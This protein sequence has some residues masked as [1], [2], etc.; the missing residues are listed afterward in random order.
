MSEARG[1]AEEVLSLLDRADA[2]SVAATLREAA[3]LIEDHCGASVDPRSYAGGS[4]TPD[5][6]SGKTDAEQSKSTGLMDRVKG[7]LP[8]RLRF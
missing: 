1:I 4:K 7:I 5:S 6:Q 2:L 3:E 8:D